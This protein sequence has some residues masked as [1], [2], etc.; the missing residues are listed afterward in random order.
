MPVKYRN[1]KMNLESPVF[2]EYLQFFIISIRN[3]YRLESGKRNLGWDNRE[4]HGPS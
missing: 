1:E 2:L 3:R 4:L